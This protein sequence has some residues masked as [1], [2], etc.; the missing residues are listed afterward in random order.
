MK[1]LIRTIED[2]TKYN[3]KLGDMIEMPEPERKVKK[4]KYIEVKE[5]D[6]N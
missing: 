3:L 6:T 1:K 5:N 2:A 4:E